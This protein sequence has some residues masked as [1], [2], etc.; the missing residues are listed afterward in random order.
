M[1]ELQK[2]S[3]VAVEY[4]LAAKDKKAKKTEQTTTA[5]DPT[6]VDTATV[7]T[8]PSAVATQALSATPPALQQ[9]VNFQNP[10]WDTFLFVFF[11]IAAFLY[12]ISLGR[13]RI[14]IILVSIYMSL[15]VVQ[16]VPEFVLHIT[17]NQNFAFQIT[18]FVSVF[19][20]LFF[21]LSRSALLNTLGEGRH[22]GGIMEVVVFSFLHVGLLISIA[23]GFLPADFVAKF[24]QLTI[25]IFTDQW[26]KFLWIV[27]PIAAMIVL[28][29]REEED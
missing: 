18:A 22:R 6:A 21:L 1:E 14:I 27:A 13:D 7:A 3:L 8:D 11:L 24:S 25:T 17:L 20:V 4:K 26:A 10:T 23:M 19:I 9:Y 16:A 12:G 15:A 29:K 2:H 28:G 5:T